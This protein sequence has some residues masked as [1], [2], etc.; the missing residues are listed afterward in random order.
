MDEAVA[1]GAMVALKASIAISKISSF[2]HSRSLTNKSLPSEIAKSKVDEIV[3][4][5][6]RRRP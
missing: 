5:V 6:V 3:R 1:I 2:L 4:I